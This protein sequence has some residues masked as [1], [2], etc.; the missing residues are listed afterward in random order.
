[1]KRNLVDLSVRVQFAIYNAQETYPNIFAT[2]SDQVSGLYVREIMSD[3]M[4]C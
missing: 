4:H 1:M 2:C 3:Y